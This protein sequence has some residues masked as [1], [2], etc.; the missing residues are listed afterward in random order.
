MA[1]V[2]RLATWEPGIDIVYYGN[3]ELINILKA[4]K[5]QH[6]IEFIWSLTGNQISNFKD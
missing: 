4:K 2:C 3:F 5:I 1:Y 6:S